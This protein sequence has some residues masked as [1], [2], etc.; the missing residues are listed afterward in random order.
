MEQLPDMWRTEVW[1][2]LFVHFPI[3]LLLVATCARLV[4]L[5]LKDQ[6]R[7]G[8]KFMSRA[9]LF[10]GVICAWG[11]IYTGDLAHSEVTRS[12]CDPTILKT[13]E[14]T[15]YTLSWLFTAAALLEIFQLASKRWQRFHKLQEALVVL[16]MVVGSGFLIYS[17]HLGASLVYQQA[18]GVYRPT[19]DCVEFQ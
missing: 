4:V 16:L 1:H 13:H 9:L 11:S 12:L 18:A 10:A 17:G 8:W 6:H 3:A 14:N 2:P 5:V 7:S 19:E 15:A